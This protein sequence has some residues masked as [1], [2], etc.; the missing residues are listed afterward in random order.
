ML[1]FRNETGLAGTIFLS[2]DPDGVDTLYAIVK[3][4]FA[5]GEDLAEWASPMPAKEQLPVALAP[6]HHGDPAASSIR[7]PS[8]MSL[9]KPATDVLLVG[10]AY[11]PRAH[12][13]PWT[14]VS[15]G[16]GALRKQVRV[17]GDRV[18]RDGAVGASM[19]Q[20]TPFERMPLVWERAFGG[21]ELVDGQPH[22]DVRNPVG[23]GFRAPSSARPLD[24]MA[25]PNLE[26][27]QHPITSWSDRPAPACFA[28]IAAHWEPRRSFA[29]TYDEA[30]QRK[31][32]PYLPGDFDARFFQ[33]APPGLVSS[34]Y[35]QGGEPV[36][37]LGALPDAVP[38]RF[39]LPAVRMTATYALGGP[40]ARPAH[41]DTVLIEPDARR[42]VLVWRAALAVDKQALR[43]S[44]IR[45]TVAR[46]A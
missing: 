25:L 36:E 29:G 23:A 13:V 40:Q 34:G 33:L 18:W 16:V 42:V 17:F 30:W 10:H 35:L 32:S 26:D 45:A 20:P 1:Q 24:G 41:L 9:V 27:P 43:V 21:T 28:P 15:L 44:E 31:R 39:R 8:D 2:P 37:V 38:L 11:A 46:A 14:D 19:S 7:V 22:A 4:T 12:A 5:L 3:G 6:E